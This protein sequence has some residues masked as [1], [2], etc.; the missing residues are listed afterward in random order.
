MQVHGLQVA[1][2]AG[3]FDDDWCEGH[4]RVRVVSECV[5]T[6]L[7]LGV[8]IPND[9][10]EVPIGVFTITAGDRPP[11]TRVV[12][13]GDPQDLSVPAHLN[14]GDEFSFTIECDYKIKKDA[15]D[16]RELAFVLTSAVLM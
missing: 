12:K 4:V 15:K 5:C 11:I 7:K 10:E 6:R 8:W 2:I 9:N 16:T 3:R 1:D 14:P 13:T